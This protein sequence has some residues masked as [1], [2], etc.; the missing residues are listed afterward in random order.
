MNLR[1]VLNPTVDAAR[2]TILTLKQPSAS[3]NPESQA[4][5]KVNFNVLLHKARLSPAIELKD[6]T[7]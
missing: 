1:V 7:Q 2:E 6:A 4:E 3:E 5:L